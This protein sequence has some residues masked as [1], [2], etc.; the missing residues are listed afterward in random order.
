MSAGVVALFVLFGV[1]L[2]GVVRWMGAAKT[3]QPGFTELTSFD[4]APKA[5][6]A[7]AVLEQAGIPVALDDH[8]GRFAWGAVGGVTR[9]LV[10]ADRIEDATRA[11][12]GDPSL[13]GRAVAGA[14]PSWAW[15]RWGLRAG[16][17]G[18]A[19]LVAEETLLENASQTLRIVAFAAAIVLVISGLLLTALGPRRDRRDEN[20]P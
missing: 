2:I 16:G 13:V 18:V 11:L 14:P 19:L 20:R 8:H 3:D 6:R 7:R 15:Q 5:M 1:L 17:L 4:E 9:V 12:Q 10:A